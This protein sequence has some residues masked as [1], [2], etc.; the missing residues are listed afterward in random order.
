MYIIAGLTTYNNTCNIP[1]TS[2][3]VERYFCAKTG[4]DKFKCEVGEK[5]SA[6][7]EDCVRGEEIFFK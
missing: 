6:I 1:F 4:L 3:F 7:L 5:G 2:G